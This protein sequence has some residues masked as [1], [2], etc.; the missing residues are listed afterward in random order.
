MA[1][2]MKI[3]GA[4][5]DTTQ[6]NH[7]S[8]IEVM[9]FQWG[10][11]RAIS[12]RTGSAADRESSEPSVSEVV[13]TKS[14]DKSSV[15]LFQMCTT[16]TDGK[17]V[18]IHFAST[19]QGGQNYLEIELTDTLISGY[20]MSS[21]GDRP[22]E[23]VSLNFTKVNVKYQELQKTGA[24]IGNPIAGYYDISTAKGG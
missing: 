22:S 18:E 2:Y 13:V 10:V 17:K 21:G 14:M 11:G 15:K 23:S 3:P 20:S 8:W 19:T 5:G 12:T 6:E 9:S 7:K 4:D 16:E 24:K 1:I